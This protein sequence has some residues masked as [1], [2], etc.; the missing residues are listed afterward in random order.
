MSQTDSRQRER[1]RE[2]NPEDNN[3]LSDIL[4][5]TNMEVDGLDQHGMNLWMT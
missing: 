1:E 3:L 4:R 2:R 5:L